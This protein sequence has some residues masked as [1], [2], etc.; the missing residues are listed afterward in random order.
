M[1][2]GDA[3]SA[4]SLPFRRYEAWVRTLSAPLSP[5]DEAT[6]SAL[7]KKN[8]SSDEEE[9]LHQNNEE[10]ETGQLPSPGQI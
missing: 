3:T 5:A 7:K 6:P 10:D 8:V 1:Y 2:Q 9:E 4:L